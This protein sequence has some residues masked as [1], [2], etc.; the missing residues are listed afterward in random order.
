MTL[1]SGDFV[2][3]NRQIGFSG[4]VKMD[5]YIDAKLLGLIEVILM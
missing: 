3:E 1:P 5:E 4:L 2:R